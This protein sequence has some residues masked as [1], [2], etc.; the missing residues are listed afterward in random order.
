MATKNC[1]CCGHPFQPRPQVPNQAYCSSPACQ[2]E[3]RQRWQ[4]DKLQN[5]LAYQDNQKRNQRA[6]LDRNPNYWRDYRDAQLQYVE[7]NDGNQQQT[8]PRKSPRPAKLVAF[9]L[10]ELRAGLYQITPVAGSGSAKSDAWIVEIT[11]VCLDCSC[12]KDACKDRT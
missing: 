9:P 3:R 5:D 10:A 11:P 4:R 2:A 12:K 1:A 7:R 6:W 8:A